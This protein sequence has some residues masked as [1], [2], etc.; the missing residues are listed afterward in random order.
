MPDYL[1][2]HHDD[3]ETIQYRYFPTR[4]AAQEEYP[5]TNFQVLLYNIHQIPEVEKG[6]LE[7]QIRC[8]PQHPD[9]KFLHVSNS[10]E[11]NDLRVNF[12][13]T[14]KAAQMEK[15]TN[16]VKIGRFLAEYYPQLPLD[17]TIE[18]LTLKYAALNFEITHDSEEIVEIYT[19]GGVGSCMSRDFEDLTSHPCY[20][21]GDDSDLSLAYMKNQF[22]QIT[23][24]AIVW[25]EKKTFYSIYG[26]QI[27]RFALRKA[28]YTESPP[29]GARINLEYQNPH[30]VIAP[31]MDGIDAC[32]IEN[33]ML[34]MQ[35]SYD[36]TSSDYF[37]PFN[38][39]GCAAI[40]RRLQ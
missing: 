17:E 2:S 33:G 38:E 13:K 8:L 22:G 1:I 30:T 40:P 20:A 36:T 39:D 10:L 26:N 24:R 7:N 15:R 37:D 4:K 28:G 11:F 29:F 35:E 19:N 32:K 14:Y 31:F 23:A 5:P 21:Y 25:V 12:F 27:L 9:V 34:V 3:P 18:R 16:D 6:Y